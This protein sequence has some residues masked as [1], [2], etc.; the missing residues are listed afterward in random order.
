MSVR[1]LSWTGQIREPEANGILHFKAESA[2]QSVQ[3]GK[4]KA[5]PHSS[6]LIRPAL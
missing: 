2:F 6:V 4:I 1:W 5:D 3:H